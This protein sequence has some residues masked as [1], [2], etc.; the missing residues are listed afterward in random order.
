MASDSH[1]QLLVGPK[2]GAQMGWIGLNND[3]DKEFLNSQV[4][5]GF[6]GGAVAIWRVRDRFYLHTELLYALNKQRITGELDRLLESEITNHML[7][8][9]ISFKV[10]FDQNIKNLKY[11][12]YLGAGPNIRYWMGG[13][14]TV[15]SSEID[16]VG[17]TAQEYKIKFEEFPAEN[18]DNSK[19]YIEDA[20][21]V[22]LGVN[23]VAGLMFQPQGGHTIILDFRFDYG[24]SFLARKDYG[25]YPDLIDYSEPTR[26]RYHAFKIGVAYLIDTNVASR[27]KGKSTANPKKMR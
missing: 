23:A 22:Q 24:H 17:T 3:A 27:N 11:Q 6:H 26:A 21:R 2:F 19:L 4:V 16:E 15:F 1:A 10:N 9:P 20:N 25:F 14:S 7:E 12:I 18:V 5:P 13:N 8:L